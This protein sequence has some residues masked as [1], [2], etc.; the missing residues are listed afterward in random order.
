MTKRV[1]RCFD[2]E[3]I[4]HDLNNLR[5]LKDVRFIVYRI[6][7]QYNLKKL[8]K[9][10]FR[11]MYYTTIGSGWVSRKTGETLF[12]FRDTNTE[13]VYDFQ[14]HIRVFK[15]F[16]SIGKPID[17]SIDLEDRVCML[18]ENYYTRYKISDVI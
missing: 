1:K 12:Q 9:E 16:E 17:H 8:K 3:R 15:V 14:S 5:G 2:V 4:K 6:L 13:E 10:L 11:L 7:W 18:P